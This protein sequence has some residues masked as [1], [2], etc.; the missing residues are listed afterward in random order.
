MLLQKLIRK[1]LQ[2][3]ANQIRNLE[4]ASSV[5]TMLNN[6]PTSHPVPRSKVEFLA[7][8][9]FMPSQSPPDSRLLKVA[10]VGFPNVGKSS[11]VNMLVN[12]RV[13]AVSGK[14]HTTRSKQTV[15]FTKDNIQLAF[16]DLPGLVSARQIRQFKLERTFIRDP[17]AAIFD[18]D[19]ILVVVDASNKYA[20]KALDPE[21]L[22]V[23]HFFADKESVLVLNKVDKSQGDRTR[24]LEAT[25]RL[26]GGLVGGRQ[27]HRDAFENKFNERAQLAERES[28]ARHHLSVEAIIFPLLPPEAHEAAQARLQHIKHLS[29]LLSPTIQIE[30]APRLKAPSSPANS[31]LPPA[32]SLPASEGSDD[33]P[34]FHLECESPEVESSFVDEQDFILQGQSNA[35]DVDLP[36]IHLTPETPEVPSSSL[37]ELNAPSE[38]S[39]RANDIVLPNNPIL[40]IGSLTKVEGE[41]STHTVDPPHLSP[42]FEAKTSICEAAA[43]STK[44]CVTDIEHQI[45]KDFFVD[46]KRAS[47][48]DVHALTTFHTSNNKKEVDFATEEERLEGMLERVRTQMMLN[49]ASKEEV[50]LRR[51][52]WREL[53]IQL[54]GVKH[55]EGFSQVFMVSAA[56]GEGIDK[57]R[58]YLLEQAKPDRQ[59]VLSPSLVTDVEPSEL[60]RMSVWAHCLD[61][62]PKEVPYGLVVT[63]D[64]CDHVRQAEGDDRVYV[65]VRLRCPNERTIKCVI[66]PRGERIRAIASAAKQ[67]LSNLFLAPTVVK[68]TAEA[69]RPTRGSMQRMR[70]AKDFAEV[71]PNFDN[72]GGSAD[73]SQHIGI[74]SAEV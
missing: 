11:L 16:V 64:E 29:A 20:R 1:T 66:G 65:H 9:L 46:Y 35:N 7:K 62:L 73:A 74:E 5:P 41:C 70:A 4:N 71:F 55:W 57:L 42:D 60:I 50:A 17:H 38:N 14:A 48:V 21:V 19:L 18:A 51:Q 40:Q 26:T 36:H 27:A 15:V 25:R 3:F 63:V 67:E 72:G 33:P 37:G 8:M 6:A 44:R 52:K 56:T 31:Y 43:V 32:S 49:S 24:L 23:L 22:K 10:V 54:Q 39:L 2:C 69:V 58:N 12:W 47:P 59:W 28:W 34:Q 45:I 30:S 13:C 61:Q 68:L 53:G